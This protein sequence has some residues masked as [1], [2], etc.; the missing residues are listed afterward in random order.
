MARVTFGAPAQRRQRT[1]VRPVS[2][3]RKEKRWYEDPNLMLGWVRLAEAL[4]APKGLIA[5]GVRAAQRWSLANDAEERKA[6]AAEAEEMES[7]LAPFRQRAAAGDEE[8]MEALSPGILRGGDPRMRQQGDTLTGLPTAKQEAALRAEYEGIPEGTAPAASMLGVP[9]RPQDI[10]QRPEL[11]PLRTDYL[12][13]PSM[14]LP[15]LRSTEL[16]DAPIDGLYD[17]GE[18][19]PMTLDV[20]PPMGP[21]T[22]QWSPPLALSRWAETPTTARTIESPTLPPLVR[23]RGGP[24]APVETEAPSADSIYQEVTV[25]ID[26]VGPISRSGGAGINADEMPPLSLN[27]EQLL[28]KYG[29][30]YENTLLRRAEAGNE[31]AEATYVRLM[32][33]A[34]PGGAPAQETEAPAPE[35][36][37]P[38]AP[39]T[40]ASNYRDSRRAAVDLEDQRTIDAEDYLA[41]MAISTVQDVY[42][43]FGIYGATKDGRLD[44]QDFADLWEHAKLMLERDPAYV[45]GMALDPVGTQRRLLSDTMAYFK[46]LNMGGDP[47]AASDKALRRENM[48]LTV[49]AKKR[50]AQKA[51]DEAAARAARSGYVPGTTVRSKLASVL[52]DRDRGVSTTV[53]IN[54]EI[55]TFDWANTTPAGVQNNRN[56]WAAALDKAD[57]GRRD[58]S[59]RLRTTSYN[60]L[61]TRFGKPPKEPTISNLRLRPATG[62]SP[63]V[64]QWEDRATGTTRTGTALDAYKSD[65]KKAE[66]MA[67]G[68]T[69]ADF[70]TRDRQVMGQGTIKNVALLNKHTTALQG[71]AA[72]ATADQVRETLDNA[73]ISGQNE[74]F[75]KAANE[76]LVANVQEEID[77]GVV[78]AARHVMKL[79]R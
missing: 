68:A 45:D 25:R 20:A 37:E 27:P 59:T 24:G 72:N 3:P 18:R 1:R 74:A 48:Q 29:A 54:G 42:K 55:F 28:E 23:L 52:N 11:P 41:D 51:K 50:A 14:P 36:P 71:L 4:A 38:E 49:D 53:E 5:R 32:G 73:G 63:A 69:E 33:L 21:T 67:L 56:T 13:P 62:T 10:Y 65:W 70:A 57:S 9:P 60:N 78:A 31:G 8:A 77:A 44:A 64:F 6:A 35:A 7:M 22:A 61:R 26:N 39:L 75:I 66:L 46:F 43:D 30:D 12:T 58:S 15:D 40:G 2:Q 16:V 79:T 76:I 47:D 34:G 17:V 19:R